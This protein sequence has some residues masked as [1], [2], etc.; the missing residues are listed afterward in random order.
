MIVTHHFQIPVEVLF[1]YLFM[2]KKDFYF[3]GKPFVL[4]E[5]QITNR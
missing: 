3:K 2:S 4:K 1:I 5:T